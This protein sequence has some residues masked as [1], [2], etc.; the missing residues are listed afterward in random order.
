MTNAT[1]TMRLIVLRH[2]QA[3]P[4]RLD[5]ASRA[6]TAAGE[7]ELRQSAAFLAERCWLPQRI[8]ASPYRRAQQTAHLM[9]ASLLREGA[10]E[11]DSLLTPDA[12]ILRC[13]QWLAASCSGTVLIASHMPL[14]A[15]LVHNLA[16]QSLA[17]PT[18][19]LVVLQPTDARWRVLAQ[20]TPG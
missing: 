5:D 8:I 1:E 14:V 11:T 12:D 20:F 9:Q 10:I 4:M 7:Q 18:G 2:G 13:S 15:D 3:E 16:G 17:F 19:S 6:L